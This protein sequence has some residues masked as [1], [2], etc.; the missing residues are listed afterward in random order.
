MK[1]LDWT[2]KNPSKVV[3][4]VLVCPQLSS[5]LKFGV[6]NQSLK[7]LKRGLVERVFRIENSEGKLVAPPEALPGAFQRKDLGE[8]RRRWLCEL[9]PVQSHSVQEVVNLFKGGKKKSY[10]QAAQSL[11]ITPLNAS[12]A[13]VA[14]F[15]KADKL[16]LS[17]KPDPAPRVIQPRK[18]RFNL[19]LGKYLRLNEKKM[20][21][22][23][24]K[25]FGVTTVLSGYDTF[26]VGR[27]LASQWK[28][29]QRPVGVGLD[30]KRFDQSLGVPA[31]K[32][33]H[34]FYLGAFP[35]SEELSE[36]LNLQLR[37][38]GV[39]LA[40]DGAIY[41]EIEGRRMSGDI[42]TSLGNKIIMCALVWAYLQYLG[43]DAYLGN[44]GDDCILITEEENLNLI[45]TTVKDWFLEYG[46]RIEAEEPVFELEQLEFCQSHPVC[47][48]G[49]WRMV[50][51]MASVSKDCF[52]LQ[53]IQSLRDFESWLAAVGQCGMALN[54]G[55][56]VLQSF[57]SA[58]IR[59]S[60]NRKV[61]RDYLYKVV[62]FGNFERLGN[63]IVEDKRGLVSL[64][65]KR[66]DISDSSRLSFFRA[67]GIEPWRQ[68]ELEQYYDSV[69]LTYGIHAVKNLPTLYSVLHPN[70]FC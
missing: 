28:R 26:T 63:K 30:A 34:S 10:E 7:N 8:F 22:A 29:F 67:T 4:K 56:P 58:F 31:L 18:P 36:L 50:R 49:H 68:L 38:I 47:I 15:I 25:V 53:S 11:L 66:Q 1:V 9:G 41:Y 19:A 17:A 6:H 54:A 2:V 16:D 33:E 62:E 24:D 60:S 43:V 57:H 64:N 5:G 27:I 42:N 40:K 52:S 12:D 32:Y 51:K 35:I 14:T 69:S 48:D 23:I 3:R 37:N 21:K 70:N 59:N 45:L 44:N 61:S 65:I 46:I 13:K 39:A 55:V 20:I